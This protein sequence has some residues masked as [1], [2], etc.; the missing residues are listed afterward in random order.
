MKLPT[1][2]VCHNLRVLSLQLD[3]Y[4]MNYQ[5][6]ASVSL[7]HRGDNPKTKYQ[8]S[9]YTCNIKKCMYAQGISNYRI[10]N[11]LIKNYLILELS[12]HCEDDNRL[13]LKHFISVIA[14]K[15]TTLSSKERWLTNVLP[16]FK[17]YKTL[18]YQGRTQLMNLRL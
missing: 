5:M 6:H 8:T 7:T 17:F 15:I 12:P 4:M 16:F 14:Y 13:L 9:G 3:Y 2:A 11:S 18:H 10:Y 1:L